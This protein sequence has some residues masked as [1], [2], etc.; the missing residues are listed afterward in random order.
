M[1]DQLMKDPNTK[2]TD[3]FFAMA[4]GSNIT[5]WNTF[6][7]TLPS[8][9]ISLTWRHYKDGGWLAKATRKNKTIFWG[10]VSD[11]YFSANFNFL[12]KSSLREGVLE[13]D[14]SDEIKNTLTHT[15]TGKWFSI[16]VD[17]CNENQ[18]S[19]LYKL[20]SYKKSAK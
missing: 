12:E 15:P 16:V 19:D 2:L 17:V 18:L 5:L 1:I 8:L 7:E 4:L 9:D 3:E 20:I 13:L 6:N 10:S 14:I 11:G